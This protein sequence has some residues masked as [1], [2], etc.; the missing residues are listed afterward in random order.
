MKVKYKLKTITPV[1]IGSGEKLTTLDGFYANRN[2]H[3]VDLDQVLAS[4][5]IDPEQLAVTLSKRDFDWSSLDQQLN[6]SSGQHCAY[7]IPC[8]EPVG[9]TEVREAVKNAFGRPYIPGSSI[10]GAL[11]TALLGSLILEDGE[12]R[13]LAAEKLDQS[14]QRGRV[15][16]EWVGQ[17][18][19]Q[20]L[21][22]K[23]PNH[24]LMRAIQVSDT[25]PIEARRLE[26][27]LAWTVTLSQ[28]Q[29]GDQLVQ[30]RQG[31][32]EYKILVEQVPA[33]ETMDLTIKIDPWLFR[34]T[35]MEQLGF[36]QQQQL[37]VTQFAQ[38]SRNFSD[39]ILKFDGSFFN[40]YGFDGSIVDFYY[41]LLDLLD[42]LPEG[43]ML[44]PVGWGTGWAAKTVTDIVTRE[45]NDLW[46]EVRNTF[47]LGR[48][49]V[50]D[51]PKTRRLLYQG[52]NPIS[53]LGW[54]QL[55]PDEDVD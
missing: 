55:T 18:I 22:G 6:L 15:R 54:V 13:Q 5:K 32:R 34:Q 41:D 36:S 27:G 37:L 46:Q 33:Q 52:Q 2:W 47:R 48:L 45:D 7:R 9:R 8:P 19:E 1:H 53:P 43:G 11:R 26:M 12:T 20:A 30:K 10:K 29:D 25:L 17:P 51:F 38:R 44:L 3:R 35:E 24:D 40:D 21:L 49:N 23:D 31:Q 16:R 42:S 4:G 14:L 39:Q 28:G 50:D